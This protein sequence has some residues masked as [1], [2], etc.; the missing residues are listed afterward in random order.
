M[1]STRWLVETESGATYLIDHNVEPH[2]TAH[3][4]RWPA[5]SNPDLPVTAMQGDRVRLEAEPRVGEQLVFFDDIGNR[6]HST[7]VTKVTRLPAP[8]PVSPESVEEVLAGAAASPTVYRTR[9]RLG[10]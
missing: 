7:P 1:T 5:G 3:L 4:L 2:A 10:R 9:Q 6:G 8:V